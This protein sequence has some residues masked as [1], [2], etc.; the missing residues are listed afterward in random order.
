M[1]TLEQAWAGEF[2]NSWCNNPAWV[3]YDLIVNKIYG[4]GNYLDKTQ[5]NKWE[6]FQIAR[7]CDELV[8][9]GVAAADL[10]SIHTTNDTNYTPSGDTTVQ[11]EPRFSA[12]LVISGKQEAYKV[13]NDVTSI[14]RGMT[15]WLNGE[16]Y[17]VQDSEKDPVY[18]FTNANVI[19]GKFAYEGTANKTRTNSIIVNWNNPQD[20]YRARQEIVELE[21]NL[22][23]DNEFL[24]P[25]ETTAFGCTS[26]GQ[27]RR[28]GKWKLLTNNWN[29]NTVSFSTSLNAAFL[30]PGDIVQITDQNKSGKSWGGR[31]STSSSTTAVNIDRKPTSFGNTSV[32]S[33]Y[34]AGD[35]MLSCS[36]V[37]YKAL[38]AQD[39]AVIDISGTN[40]TVLRGTEISTWRDTDG[41][42][43]A[44]KGWEDGSN[45]I[46]VDS[47]EKAASVFDAN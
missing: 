7:Y 46:T 45:D 37:G 33:G 12:N 32:E 38:L 1:E 4:L 19:D 21:E 8:P 27:A 25:E 10:L 47:E 26:R 34:A 23:K 13:L 11:Y 44:S 35:Y 22:Q 6:L 17:V 24:K 9:A 15:Y 18:Q 39:S 5:I 42:I 43:D 29:T 36:F 14:F 20:Y 41:I 16:A 31:I 28:L 3:Y 40:T 30:R 2:Y